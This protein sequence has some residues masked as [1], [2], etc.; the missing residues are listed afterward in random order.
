MISVPTRASTLALLTVPLC[1]LLGGAGLWLGITSSAVVWWGFG[2][3]C[4]L[5]IPMALSLRSR[6]LDGLGN[7]GLERE[8]L[9]LRA[10]GILLRLVA[11]GLGLA[12][13]SALLEGGS[14]QTRPSNLV[15]ALLA[16]VLLAVH[17][18]AKHGLKGLHP[19]LDLDAERARTLLEL[20]VL[21]LVGCLLWRWFPLG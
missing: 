20:A 17:G 4:L 18:Y 9:T 16:V 7:S 13:G 1:L 12:A 15:G 21:L 8:R 11:L 3:A 10:I 2:A 5:Q 14:T 6:I 19:A